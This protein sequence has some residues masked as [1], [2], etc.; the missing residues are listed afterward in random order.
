M[1]IADTMQLGDVIYR[2]RG[3]IILISVIFVIIVW[4][5][6]LRAAQKN[7]VYTNTLR[8]KYAVLVVAS[9]NEDPDTFEQCLA[10]IREHGQPTQLLISI[11]DATH[12]ES[13]LSSIAREYA[14]T[15]VEQSGMLSYRE[16][17]AILAQKVRRVTIVLVTDPTTRWTASTAN[18]LQPFTDEKTGF[19]SGRLLYE[20]RTTQ[21]WQR[22]GRW[23]LD[24]QQGVIL[25]FQSF[26]KQAYGV[27]H[28]TTYAVRLK[29]LT[30]ALDDARSLP[31]SASHPSSISLWLTQQG[32]KAHYQSSA[33]SVLNYTLSLQHIID[34]YTEVSR[35][36]F[37][38]LVCRPHAI[39]GLQW[40]VRLT[41][42]GF[43]V[44]GFVYVSVIL[45]LLGTLI[46]GWNILLIPFGLSHYTGWSIMVV[47]GVSIA[48]LGWQVVRNLPHLRRHPRD[49][50]FLPTYLV[51][52]GG[53]ALA[54][55]L[56]GIASVSRQHE[57]DSS[58]PV[59]RY[60]ATML[61]VFIVLVTVPF[62]YF[63][64]IV[65]SPQLAKTES[66]QRKDSP[67]TAI[68]TKTKEQQK[69]APLKHQNKPK[70]QPQRRTAK[71][72]ASL[73]TMVVTAQEG[74]SQSSLARN[75]IEGNQQ[76]RNLTAAQQAYIENHLVTAMGR[77]DDIE[78]GETFTVSAETIQTIIS[79]AKI[80]D[81]D[82]QARWNKYV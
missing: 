20:R 81:N 78:I 45:V 15:V 80:L 26:Y 8:K 44:V 67:N 9:A 14:T 65:P 17:L 39:W 61:A 72:P 12:A 11:N 5:L 13:T 47:C 57:S 64:A 49:V 2:C 71:K 25:P 35:A 32:Y 24:V 30:Q 31:V 34:H 27:I 1:T 21:I 33:C 48:W 18:V 7:T 82:A 77:R 74:D 75:Y 38:Q 43:C 54:S 79:A 68:D 23:M 28:H 60:A 53:V 4:I 22:V 29:L 59:W 10:S 40:L 73:P 69:S 63:V 50:W 56:W 36:A 76:L 66:T 52:A 37:W 55:K 70:N 51:A 6:R 42:I 46:Q 16:Q 41:H 62:V 3:W 58:H 19:V